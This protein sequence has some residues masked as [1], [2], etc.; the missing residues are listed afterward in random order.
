MPHLYAG[1]IALTA[2]LFLSASPPVQAQAGG[3]GA[4]PTNSKSAITG[5]SGK[6][7]TSSRRSRMKRSA[8]EMPNLP[9]RR[10]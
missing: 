6:K 1:A 2:L 9:G 4:G 3:V 5:Q 8:I 10:G 7:G